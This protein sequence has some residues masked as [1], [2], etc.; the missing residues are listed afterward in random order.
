MGFTGNPANQFGGL[1]AGGGVGVQPPPE[2]V[3]PDNPAISA[4][5]PAGT[6]EAGGATIQILGSGFQS[7]D[8]VDV[9]SVAV[10]GGNI[11][12]VDSGQINFVVP[13]GEGQVDVEVTRGAFTSNA[14]TLTYTVPG[15]GI[16]ANEPAGM[17]LILQRDCSALGESW[18]GGTGGI[19]FDAS[20]GATAVS[21]VGEPQSASGALQMNWPQGLGGGGPNGNVGS[22]FWTPQTTIYV[23]ITHK[24]SSNWQG[25]NSGTN[26]VF[27]LKTNNPAQGAGNHTIWVPHGTGSATMTSHIHGQNYG[28][29]APSVD[30]TP[31]VGSGIIVRGVWYEMEFVF[32]AN[33]PGSTNGTLQIW[34]NGVQSHNYTNWCPIPSGAGPGFQGILFSYIWGGKDDVVQETMNMRLGHIYVSGKS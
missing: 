23:Y 4:L 5:S 33:T 8:G 10:A 32:I 27:F 1:G 2:P 29:G 18:G 19:N 28:C 7:G 31:N 34:Q 22:R 13:A 24:T 25:H 12:F 16:G 15:T 9:N 30:I 11:T 6:A 26:K 17:S 21:D 14:S 20:G 3:V